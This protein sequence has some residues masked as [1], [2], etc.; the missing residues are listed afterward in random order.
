MV[1]ALKAR[2]SPIRTRVA[3]NRR[4][5][6]L[7]WLSSLSFPVRSR[8]AAMASPCGVASAAW[9]PP[10][11]WSRRFLHHFLHHILLSSS[12]SLK[13]QR[14][15]CSFAFPCRFFSL[16]SRAVPSNAFPAIYCGG[17]RSSRDPYLETP[18]LRDLCR[19]KVPEHILQ[20]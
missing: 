10:K 3:P 5:D 2:W 13:T 19:D 15:R 1:R 11:A 4:L 18:T 9:P 6:W 14:G 12:R 17:A 20:R 7:N 16:P 8:R